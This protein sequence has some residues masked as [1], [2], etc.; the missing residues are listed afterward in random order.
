VAILYT[1]QILEAL[2]Y[3]HQKRIIHCDV[4][5]DNL[6]LF[7]NH[8][9]KLS[10]FGIAKTMYRKVS[11]SGRGTVGYLAPE[12]AMGKPSFR[13][14]LFSVGLIIYR[15]LSGKLPEW[16]YEWPLPGSRRLRRVVSADMIDLLRRSLE[17]DARRRFSDAGTLLGAFR[18]IRSR[19]LIADGKEK[20]GGA[21]KSAKHWKAVRQ[22]QFLRRF[23][24]ALETRHRC[25]RCGNPVSEEMA[26]CPWCGRGRQTHRGEHRFPARCPRCRRGLKLDWRFC[27]WCYGGA[28]GPLSNRTYNDKRYVSKCANP[29]CVEKDQMPFMRY[30]PWCKRKTKRAWKI[31]ASTDKCPRC[32]WGIVKEYWRY[33]PWC[34][35]RVSA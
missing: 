3:A 4:K 23:G 14:D 10:D 15:M 17:V 6:I 26:F 9:L 1:E 28:V 11:G 21:G 25:S 30:C 31:P 5:P 35:A 19:A 27:P 2:A 22:K 8:R 13:S 32:R 12:Q 7:P 33:C 20:K 18:R 34:G 16:P 24:S 29:D